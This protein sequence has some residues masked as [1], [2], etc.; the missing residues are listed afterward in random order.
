MLKVILPPHVDDSEEEE[1]PK[2]TTS[3]STLNRNGIDCSNNSMGSQN[4]AHII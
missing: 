2:E 3:A 4:R 1:K